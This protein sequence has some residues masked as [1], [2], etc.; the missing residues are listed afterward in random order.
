MGSVASDMCFGFDD[1]NKIQKTS[2]TTKTTTT[3]NQT[4]KK[5]AKD[6]TYGAKLVAPV[7]LHY[8]LRVIAGGSWASS[9]PAR[10][11]AVSLR[12]NTRKHSFSF[13][14][15]FLFGVVLR[16][17]TSRRS[18][19][20]VVKVFILRVRCTDGHGSFELTV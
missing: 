12:L 5:M 4:E 15:L 8:H 19:C 7:K 14:C 18:G 13:L 10:A 1:L 6:G 20:V 17:H 2:V 3:T 11:K 16:F 9:H